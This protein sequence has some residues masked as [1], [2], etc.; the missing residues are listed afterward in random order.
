MS[1]SPSGPSNSGTP[2]A[3]GGP[4]RYIRK[5]KPADPLR[6]NQGRPQRA[7]PLP[8]SA[9]TRP[10][11][12][13]PNVKPGQAPLGS[14]PS[15]A[16]GPGSSASNGASLA[17]APT[18]FTSKPEGPYTDYPLFTTKRALR[19]GLRYH[20][21][22]FTGRKIIDPS[23]QNQFTRPVTLQRRNAQEKPPGKD[24][25]D[26]DPANAL[27]LDDKE[28]EKLEIARLEKEAQRAADL[29]QIAPTGNNPSALAAK[30]NASFKNE[31]TT[32]VYRIAENEEQQREFDLRY[33][34]ALP[35]HLEDA[36]NKHTWVG[37]YEAALS[38][39][40]VILFIDGAT[41]K[42]VPIDKWYRFTPK[43]QFKTLTSE[44]AEA[45]MNKK[46]KLGRWAMHTEL[47]KQQDE[48]RAETRRFFGA[49]VKVKGESQTFKRAA[50]SEVQDADD[51]DVDDDNLFQDDD[52]QPSFEPDQDEDTK[53]ASE[54]IRREQLRA[55][56]FGERDQNEVE[57]EEEEEVREEEAKK[58]LGKKMKKR[59]KKREK[60]L[61]YESDSS[62]PYSTSVRILIRTEFPLLTMTRATTILLMK[63]RRKKK[64]V[65]K[66]RKQSLKPSQPQ[67]S[68]QAPHRKGPIP[69]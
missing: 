27:Q 38:D 37:A 57:K 23:D 16:S 22:R 21:A 44:E 10:N 30:K 46:S 4:P 65:R 61:I 58:K 45:Q 19:D 67:K 31:K 24:V 53:Y 63:R 60:N 68:R 49:T 43:N 48:E 6:K 56:N 26:E 7:P 66:R 14:A 41:F 5:P 34:E 9:T 2:T 13:K 51:I 42:M 12:L 35:W 29:A 18:T 17:I 55:N 50:K 8:K 32:Q 64:S 40:N 39:T 47:Q 33:M 59:L 1:A 62:H 15:R 20:V 11:G 25:K 28:Q 69:R 54:K 52:E 3:N 36:E